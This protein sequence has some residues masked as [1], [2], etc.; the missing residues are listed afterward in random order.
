MDLLIAILSSSLVATLAQS[1]IRIIERKKDSGDA[2]KKALMLLLYCKIKEKAEQYISNQSISQDDY[3][4]I[5][6]LHE[7]YHS[8]GGNGFLDKLMKEIEEL[9][10]TV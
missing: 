8:L 6:M 4:D 7:V 9:T 2:S 5:Q 10:F 1:L 3:H